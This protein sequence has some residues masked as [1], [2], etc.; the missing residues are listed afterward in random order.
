MFTLAKLPYA[1]NSLEPYI[2]EQT[3]ITH[4]DKHHQGYVDNLNK[5][6]AG[7]Q[8]LQDKTVE[9]LL[10]DLDKL[11]VE[12]RT[13]VKNHGGG[14]ANHSL[15]WSI[16]TKNQGVPDN[17]VTKAIISDFGSFDKFKDVFSTTAASVFGSGWAWLV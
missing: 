6:I 1:Y 17:Q 7:Y 12:I 13:L 16:L 4:H 11:P 2:D 10:S 8:D 5:A 14:H 3:M 9:Q 15:F